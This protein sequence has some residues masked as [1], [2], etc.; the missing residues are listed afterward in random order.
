M[1]QRG[2]DEEHDHD[3]KGGDEPRELRVGARC[4]LDGAAGERARRGVAVEAWWQGAPWGQSLR[5]GAR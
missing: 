2:G 5:R 1:E 3:D 4:A